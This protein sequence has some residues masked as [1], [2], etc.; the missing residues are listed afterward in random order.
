ML[1]V[2]PNCATSYK[3][4][5]TSLGSEGR[6]VRCARCKVTWFAAATASTHALALHAPTMADVGSDPRDGST[7][8]SDIP[9]HGEIGTVAILPPEPFPHAVESDSPPLVPA[10]VGEEEAEAPPSEDVESIAAKRQAQLVPLPPAR[11]SRRP[12]LAFYIPVLL[13]IIVAA[14]AARTPIVRQ[15]SQTASLFAAIGLPVNLRGL[16]FNDVVISNE[17]EN[18]VPVMIVQGKIRNI[19]PNKVQVPHIRFGVQNN[20]NVEVYAW[21]ALPDKTMLGAGETLAFRSQLASPPPEAK[22]VAVRF[23]NAHDREPGR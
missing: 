20:A 22:T 14:M 12:R 21:T 23:A 17:T 6:T 8:P 3:I 1:I 2:C 11:P 18:N 16:E 13:A 15:F 7:A 19:T 4:E 5:E 9:Q 10:A